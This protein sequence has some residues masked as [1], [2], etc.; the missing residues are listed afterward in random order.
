VH[1]ANW[2]KATAIFMNIELD[3]TQALPSVQA[4]RVVKI[5]KLPLNALDSRLR[6]ND[7]RRGSS[8]HILRAGRSGPGAE[9]RGFRLAPV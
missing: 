2:R 5:G 4:Y 3:Q 1:L 7:V 8:T 6:G 9:N